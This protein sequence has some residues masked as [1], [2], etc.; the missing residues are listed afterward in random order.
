MEVFNRTTL[1]EDDV[2]ELTKLG[3]TVNKWR[4]RTI[5]LYQHPTIEDHV[6]SV[7][8]SFDQTFTVVADEP[9]DVW[10]TALDYAAQGKIY[11]S[12]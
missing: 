2:N 9:K 1:S 11:T 3:F 10:A 7:G 12:E 4:K 8:V 5:T 6:I